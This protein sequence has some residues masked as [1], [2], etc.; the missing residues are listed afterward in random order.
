MADE[1][2]WTVATGVKPVDPA[3][4]G[5]VSL[6]AVKQRGNGGWSHRFID[7]FLWEHD[8]GPHDIVAWRVVG[9]LPVE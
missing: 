4:D 7:D 5:Y 1:I 9:E 6:I 2:K 8:K 3:K